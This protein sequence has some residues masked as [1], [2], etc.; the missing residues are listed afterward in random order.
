MTILATEVATFDWDQFNFDLFRGDKKTLPIEADLL[1]SRDNLPS[2][3]LSTMDL[4]NNYLPGYV[5]DTVR[6]LQADYYELAT[7]ERDRVLDN[8][9]A[10]Q[11]RYIEEDMKTYIFR[12]GA[13]QSPTAH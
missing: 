6:V 1:F 4:A 7:G 11:L 9:L 5:I 8:M 10:V 13:T 12:F 2:V 3:F